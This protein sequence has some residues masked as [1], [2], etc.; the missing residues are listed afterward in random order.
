MDGLL[1]GTSEERAANLPPRRH[2][3]SDLLSLAQALP[4]IPS[5]A[6]GSLALSRPGAP[7]DPGAFRP[8]S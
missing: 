5:A 4:A 1:R 2:Q 3:P 8:P 7:T 6:W